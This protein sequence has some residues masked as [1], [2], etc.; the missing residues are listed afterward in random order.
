MEGSVMKINNE[1]FSILMSFVMGVVS[2]I[3][4]VVMVGITN[5]FW[6]VIFISSLIA[7]LVYLVTSPKQHGEKY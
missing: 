1:Q 5:G 4:G 7:V 2:L 6:G 3:L